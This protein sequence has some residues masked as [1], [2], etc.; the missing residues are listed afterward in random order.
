MMVPSLS[1][2]FLFVHPR[3]QGFR[4]FST[5]DKVDEMMMQMPV[6]EEVDATADATTM[7]DQLASWFGKNNQ[8]FHRSRRHPCLFIPPPRCSAVFHNGKHR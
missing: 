1:L 5:M 7:S 6:K 2:S 4:Q 8:W 3:P